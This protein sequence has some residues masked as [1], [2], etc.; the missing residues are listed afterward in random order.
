ML[1]WSA[2]LCILPAMTFPDTPLTRAARA[3]A[4]DLFAGKTRRG[5]SPYLDGH[6][7]PVAQLAI[8]LY[9]ERYTRLAHDNAGSAKIIAR[10]RELL[11]VVC[12]HH[13]TEEDILGWTAERVALHLSDQGLLTA[14]EHALIVNALT[15]LNKH[16]YD[17]YLALVLAAKGLWLSTFAKR[18]DLMHNSSDSPSEANRQKYQLALHILTT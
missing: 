6:L 11:Y 3:L 2:H 13:D 4:A 5:G 7:D 12:I 14:E 15:R 8:D 16:L 9:D 17:T 1:D 10:E 18:A